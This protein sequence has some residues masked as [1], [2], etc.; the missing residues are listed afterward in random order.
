MADPSYINAATGALTD[1][2]AWVGIAHAALSLPAALVT[3]TSTNDGQTGDFS[4]YMDL[5]CIVYARAAAADGNAILWVTF[6][7][8]TSANYDHQELRSDGGTVAPASYTGGARADWG[9]LNANTATANVFGVS[10]A[11]VFDINSGKYKSWV[12]QSADDRDGSGYQNNLTGVW[13]SQAPIT[14]IDL[15]NHHSG[16]WMAGSTF[17]LFGILPSMLTTGTVA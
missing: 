15:I 7:N 17:D 2:E 13:K 4:Q 9:Y 1:G 6:T 16:D 8:D 10:V 14:E 5:I 11:Q 12:A 3:F